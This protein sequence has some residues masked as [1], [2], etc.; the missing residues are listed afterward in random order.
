MSTLMF[1]KFQRTLQ[2]SLVQMDAPMES[3][4][5]AALIPSR[6]V[7]VKATTM[8]ASIP[9][10]R[11]KERKWVGTTKLR[12]R[13]ADHLVSTPLAAHYQ[14]R[15]QETSAASTTLQKLQPLQKE[16]STPEETAVNFDNDSKEVEGE[17]MNESPSLQG[18]AAAAAEDDSDN[19]DYV[20]TKKSDQ[21]DESKSLDPDEELQQKEEQEQQEQVPEEPAPKRG[22]GVPIRTNLDYVPGYFQVDSYRFCRVGPNS[23]EG[24]PMVEMPE[25]PMQVYHQC[26]GPT[27]NQFAMGLEDLIKDELNRP[28]KSKSPRWGKRSF[29]L[30]FVPTSVS[31]KRERSILIMGNSHTQQLVSTLL[32][33]LS[34]QLLPENRTVLYH[35]SPEEDAM[36]EDANTAMALEVKLSQNTK[37]VVVVNAPFMHSPQWEKSLEKVLQRSLWSFD[38]IVMG[39][40][41]PAPGADPLA[42]EQKLLT[43]QKDHPE[44]ELDTKYPGPSITEVASTFSGTIVWAGMFSETAE[45][46]QRNV[47]RDILSLKSNIDGQNRTNVRAIDSRRF[48]RKLKSQL[49]QDAKTASDECAADERTGNS[50]TTTCL[51]DRS[52]ELYHEGYRCMG[53]LG[54]HPDLVVWDLLEILHQDLVLARLKNRV[55]TT[56]NGRPRRA[57]TKNV[58]VAARSIIVKQRQA[59][60]RGGRQW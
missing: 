14:Q 50:L 32:C 41:A 34:S 2:Q 37:I 3:G 17:T 51:T 45:S 21:P 46:H 22:A 58:P 54:G 33:Q 25:L 24:D 6:S 16:A 55:P 36:K 29:L 10:S 18:A 47:V 5:P 8:R 48:V 49:R 13:R 56:T 57:S 27:Y 11:Q 4:P 12:D 28:T 9:N 44:W 60:T 40:F 1:G 23:E 31:N 43:L 39:S 59:T 52:E 38:A 53:A 26:A 30:P 35:E 7:R 42:R 19:A 20:E 15:Q